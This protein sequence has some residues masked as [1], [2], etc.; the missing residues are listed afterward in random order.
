M[1]QNVE[2]KSGLHPVGR[3]VLVRPY[4][5]KHKSGS[6][7]VIP[8]SIKERSMMLEDRAIVIEVGP[9]AWADEKVA[10]AAPGD[11]VIIAKFA[12][13]IAV[14]ADE[15]KYR[16]VNANDIFCRVEQGDSNA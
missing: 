10:R 8:D 16:I 3:A 14:G 13:Y 9:G 15:E 12:G 11:H 4:E 7:I 6:H 5:Q 2:N 1:L